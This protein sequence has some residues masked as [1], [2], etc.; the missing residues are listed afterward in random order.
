MATVV[1]SLLP[2]ATAAAL[3]ARLP[4]NCP[5]SSLSLLAGQ[6]ARNK[7]GD[8]LETLRRA[9]V[10]TTFAVFPRHRLKRRGFRLTKLDR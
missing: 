9:T 8:E 3:P 4:T 5:A 2:C 7:N 6:F 1:A 10:K